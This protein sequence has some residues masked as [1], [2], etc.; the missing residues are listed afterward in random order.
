MENSDVLKKCL[1]MENALRKMNKKEL[2]DVKNKNGN[3]FVVCVQNIKDINKLNEINN[4]PKSKE[5]LNYKFLLGNIRIFKNKEEMVDEIAKESLVLNGFSSNDVE[6]VYYNME[7]FWDKKAFLK[8][9]DKRCWVKNFDDVK[10]EKEGYLDKYFDKTKDV[11]RW[12]MRKENLMNEIK[13][14]EKMKKIGMER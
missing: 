13:E 1:Q 9:I 10:N 6:D 7:P 5:S 8:E 2:L 14:N 4:N 12:K 11:F 3:D